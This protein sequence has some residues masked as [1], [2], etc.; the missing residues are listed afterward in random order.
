MSEG[1]LVIYTGGTIG[2][3]PKDPNDPSSPQVVVSGDEFKHDTKLDDFKFPVDM[4]SLPNPIDSCNMTPS[5]WKW[6]AGKIK[7]TYEKYNG[8]VILHGTDSMVYTASILSFMLENLGKPVVLTG[9]QRAHLF[10]LRND[11]LQ[12]I[13]SAITIANPQYYGLPVIPEVVV[14]FGTEILRG[15][16]TRKRDANG[17]TAYE[18]PKYPPLGRVG[19]NIDIREELLLRRDP[20]KQFFVRS[21]IEPNVVYLQVFPG[22]QNTNFTS[23]ILGDKQLKGVVCGAFGAGNIPTDAAYLGQFRSAIA[24]GKW[25]QAVTQCTLGGVELGLYET[26]NLLIDVGF[27][28]GTDLTPEAALCKMMIAVG[29][30]DLKDNPALLREYLQTSVAGEQS[31]SV[32]ETKYARSGAAHVEAGTDY[33]KRR[34]QADTPLAGQWRPADVSNVQLR[35]YGATVTCPAEQQSVEIEIYANLAS[36]DDPDPS[37]AN[38]CGN[39]KRRPSSESGVISFDVTRTVRAI[40]QTGRLLPFTVVMRGE[41]GKFAWTSAEL[42][43]FAK[44]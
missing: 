4:V 29:D 30:E 16:R 34:L 27:V 43:I 10:N 2:S 3:K 19:A 1:V 41:S 32:F 11:A 38:F 12:N 20:T 26:S 5:E 9:A 33:T 23:R 7:E 22:L 28:S 6:I 44:A 37:A 21:T 39:F 18:S 25:V 14:L 17:Y 35:F 36:G 31:L 24:D 15:N 40:A 13:I 42:A 8:F